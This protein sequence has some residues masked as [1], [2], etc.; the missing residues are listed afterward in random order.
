MFVAAEFGHVDR[1]RATPVLLQHEI[2]DDAGCQ[3]ERD[4]HEHDGSPGYDE[5]PARPNKF[6][7][8]RDDRRRRDEGHEPHGNVARTQINRVVRAPKP[9]T[10][11]IEEECGEL[12]V[13][14]GPQTKDEADRGSDGER[15][16]EAGS[17]HARNPAR[18]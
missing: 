16:H 8:E 9:S 18:V 2:G 1:A 13:E 11:G 17:V 12:E 6:C 14:V 4:Q 10:L 15:D 5:R 3:R 7:R